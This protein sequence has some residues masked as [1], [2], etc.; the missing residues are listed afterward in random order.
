MSPLRPS[1]L[2]SCNGCRLKPFSHRNTTNQAALGIMQMVKDIVI[3]HARMNPL[4]PSQLVRYREVW[5]PD[6]GWLVYPQRNEVHN[7]CGIE[8][9][10]QTDMQSISE[11]MFLELFYQFICEPCFFDT[12][13]TREQL[14]LSS[15]VGHVEPMACRACDSS[16]SQKSHLTAQKRKQSEA[17]LITMEKSIEDMTEEAF[18]KHVQALAIH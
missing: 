14:G 1:Y 13:L 2:S 15:S 10:H 16:S 18:Q 7:N 4:L 12:L 11:N 6:R 8:I 9:Y 5:L 3:E 17:F